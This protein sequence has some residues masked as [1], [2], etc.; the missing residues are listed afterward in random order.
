[1]SFRKTLQPFLR[2]GFFLAAVSSL[3]GQFE[4]GTVLGTIRDQTGA[5][6]AS[7]TVTLENVRTGVAAKTVTN[8]Q[9]DYQ[10]VNVRLGSYRIRTETPG[11]QT[12]VTEEFEVRTDS[13]Q[14]VDVS[15]QVGQVS[16]SVTVTGAAA[17]LETD[18]S[19][20][21]QVINPKQIVDRSFE[22]ARLC[23]P[24]LAGS[25]RPQISARESDRF[26]P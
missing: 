26:Q 18:N 8:A 11:F 14:R 24:R 4:S 21:G 5:F 1:M 17:V 20:R 23:R 7:S 6:V 25:R 16:D 19:S 13:R 3:F 22:R 15:L 12:A 2:V 10:F 9:G